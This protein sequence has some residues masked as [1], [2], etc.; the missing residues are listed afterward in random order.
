MQNLKTFHVSSVDK[1]TQIVS[2]KAARHLFQVVLVGSPNLTEISLPNLNLKGDTI[3]TLLYSVILRAPT[4]K[5]NG[6]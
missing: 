2:D 1:N 6:L 5:D 3:C 4:N